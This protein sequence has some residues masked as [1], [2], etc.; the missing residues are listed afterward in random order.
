MSSFF[1]KPISEPAI[2]VPVTLAPKEFANLANFPS[3]QARSKTT[4]PFLYLKFFLS[5]EL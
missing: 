3:P 1:A 5:L 4:S 2:S